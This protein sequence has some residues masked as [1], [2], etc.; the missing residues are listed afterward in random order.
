MIVIRDH[1]FLSLFEFLY[2]VSQS[3]FEGYGAV[4]SSR[5]IVA[6]EMVQTALSA[7]SPR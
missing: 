4:C 5:T 1:L 6:V 7:S 3:F 2:W